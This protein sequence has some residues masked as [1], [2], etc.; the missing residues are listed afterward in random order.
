MFVVGVRSSGDEGTVEGEGDQSSRSNSETLT[1]GSS[2]VTGGIELIGSLSDGFTH[3]AHFNNTTSIVRDGTV[4]IDSKTNSHGGEH[5]EGTEGNTEHTEEGVANESGDGE[6][7]NGDN[8]GEVTKSQTLN[9]VSGSTSFTRSSNLL[10]GGVIVRGVVF[11]D[12]TNDQT[13]PE[14]SQTAEES[15]DGSS[16]FNSLEEDSF[17]KRDITSEVDSGGGEEGGNEQLDGESSSNGS[18]I[19]VVLVVGSKGSEDRNDNTESSNQQRIVQSRGL[20][21][22]SGRARTNNQSS[23]SSF[24]ERTE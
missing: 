4:S 1:N 6:E 3:F 13:R 22:E 5:T 12:V 19:F 11:G 17:G 16:F 10:N 23:A 7:D 2:G 24:S 8:G 14:T 9:D 20:V 21:V 18:Q 15:V